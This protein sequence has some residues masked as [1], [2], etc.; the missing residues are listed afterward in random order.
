MKKEIRK[1]IRESVNLLFE[2]FD[3]GKFIDNPTEAITS[4]QT[5]DELKDC[6][7]NMTLGYHFPFNPPDPIRT[8]F[9]NKMEE[10]MQADPEG[11]KGL[12]IAYNQVAGEFKP[13]PPLPPGA[14][15]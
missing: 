15:Y 6:I 14:M 9:R 7:K 10:L 12:Q 1:L 8:A 13:T 11:F 3:F 2:E 5:C 4:I